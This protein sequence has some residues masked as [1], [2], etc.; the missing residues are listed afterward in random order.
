MPGCTSRAVTDNSTLA[1]R[2]QLALTSLPSPSPSSPCL[3]FHPTQ[4]AE[5]GAIAI[6][7]ACI[8]SLHHL[9][10]LAVLPQEAP[11]SRVIA[12]VGS[13]AL[14]S[15]L[16]QVRARWRPSFHFAAQLCSCSCATTDSCVVVARAKQ[17]STQLWNR[18]TTLEKP[19]T[20]TLGPNLHSRLPAC[21]LWPIHIH[22]QCRKETIL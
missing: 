7:L 2:A 16:L 17:K 21:T 19:G 22:T 5:A 15:L 12:L 10:W 1:A 4:N 8:S 9:G 14:P 18:R 13:A 6:C 11:L 3:L 20:P